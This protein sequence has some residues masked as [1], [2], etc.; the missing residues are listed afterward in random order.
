[1]L[2]SFIGCKN[3]QIQNPIFAFIFNHIAFIFLA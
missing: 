1:M 2:A 3:K